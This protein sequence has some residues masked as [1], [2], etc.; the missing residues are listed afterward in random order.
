MNEIVDTR[1]LPYTVSRL[2][3]L[4]H[5]VR[6]NEM[7]L[8]LDPSGR[9]IER[10]EAFDLAMAIIKLYEDVSPGQISQENDFRLR[11]ASK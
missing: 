3:W 10:E 8:I 4:G 9:A 11:K 1:K 5:L 7:G 6:V 2:E